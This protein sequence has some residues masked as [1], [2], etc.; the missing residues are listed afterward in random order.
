MRPVQ[1]LHFL[2]KRRV[3]VPIYVLRNILM[4]NQDTEYKDQS[5]TTGILQTQ[6]AIRGRIGAGIAVAARHLNSG[7]AKRK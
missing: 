7:S 4:Y 6:G 5:L 2:Q 3:Y 1:A